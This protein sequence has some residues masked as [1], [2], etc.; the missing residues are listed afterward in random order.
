MYFGRQTDMQSI[1]SSHKSGVA[2][3]WR[4]HVVPFPVM[5]SVIVV[6]VGI[7]FIRPINAQQQQEETGLERIRS[8]DLIESLCNKTLYFD[9]CNSSLSAYPGA[10]QAKRWEFARIAA[11]L[12]R[13]DAQIVT[14]YILT[15]NATDPASCAALED[16]VEVLDDMVDELNDCISLMADS[17]WTQRADDVK[18]WLS[19]ALTYPYTCIEGFTDEDVDMDQNMKEK[20]EYL[21][22]FTSNALAIASYL[23][24]EESYKWIADF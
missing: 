11:E 17:N 6:C 13:N 18:T 10:D 15:L 1:K 12:S 22:K 2:R 4:G 23:S 20:S 7:V 14:D 16:C 19:A 5:C 8:S 3:S 9:V 21:K 24:D